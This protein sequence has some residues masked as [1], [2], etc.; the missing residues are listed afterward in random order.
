[1]ITTILHCVGNVGVDGGHF[2]EVWK[3][4]RS[5]HLKLVRRV[6]CVRQQRERFLL[7]FQHS[8][9]DTELGQEVVLVLVVDEDVDLRDSILEAPVG[10]K[11]RM[12][13]RVFADIEI[14]F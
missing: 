10:T 7:V 4:L 11:E 9:T 6:S 2:D 1:M 3:D 13:E 14:R 5:R 12:E 8:D